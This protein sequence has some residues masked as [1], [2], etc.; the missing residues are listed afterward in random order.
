MAAKVDRAQPLDS[1]LMQETDFDYETV[2]LEDSSTDQNKCSNKH[3]SLNSSKLHQA[4]L[5][6]C[7]TAIYG[8]R[9]AWNASAKG[10]LLHSFRSAKR[11]QILLGCFF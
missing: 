2:V 10:L 8:V 9:A 1:M 11:S 4:G 6:R 5:S 7:W 3:F